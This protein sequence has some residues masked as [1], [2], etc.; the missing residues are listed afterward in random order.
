MGLSSSSFDRGYFQTR[1]DR[2][3]SLAARSQSPE[4]RAIHL[5]YI[6]LYQQL[7]DDHDS[8]RRMMT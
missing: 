6:R 4:I 3:L 5:E 8:K 2:N 1:L 7:L